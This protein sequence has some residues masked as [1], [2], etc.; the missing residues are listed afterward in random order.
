[1]QRTGETGA[2]VV[3]HS[4]KLKNDGVLLSCASLRLRLQ[5]V[6]GSY[7]VLGQAVVDALLDLGL[8]RIR[9]A[10]RRMDHATATSRT[11]IS[12]LLGDAFSLA[13]GANTAQRLVE[14][15]QRA[16][17]VQGQ[18]LYLQAFVGVA[19]A[20][21]DGTGRELLDVQAETALR[22]AML[23]QAGAVTCFEA[24]MKG[25]V[26]AR[27]DLIADLRKALPLRQLEVYYQPQIE[28][29][30]CRLTGFEALL[31]W[32]HPTLGLV[33]PDKFIPLAEEIG[34]ISNLGNWVLKTACRQVAQ[35]PGDLRIAVN[36]SPLQLRHGDV[37]GAVQEA[38][39]I[40]KPA[41]DRLE[42]EITEGVLLERSDQI[43]SILDT[44]HGRGVKLAID[45]FGTG[46]SSLGQ[47]GQLPFDTIK[48]DRSL[49]R[50]GE[51]N[52]TIVRAIAMLGAGLGMSTLIEGIETQEDFHNAWA[53]GCQSAQGYLFG[54]P[55]PLEETERLVRA[56][57][58]RCEVT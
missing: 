36:V 2:A 30:S 37:L 31:R 49:V 44:L 15:V 4:G 45:D 17:V 58:R 9:S 32:K 56:E 40:S 25:R 6:K 20:A 13:D 34:I 54:R 16:Y 29:P 33:P 52:R 3:I 28:L 23:E 12:I 35:L 8:E 42:L 46:Y 43:R 27:Q 39:L 5:P 11:E 24:E 50:T 38:L 51:R 1:M 55:A 53:D 26:Q 21:S 14:L 7:E 57:H 22:F 10:L 48:I 19:S 18:V 41:P 47:L